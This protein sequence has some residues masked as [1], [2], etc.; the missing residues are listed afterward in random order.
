MPHGWS[1]ADF[2]AL[3]TGTPRYIA[4]MMRHATRRRGDWCN[5][6]SICREHYCWLE[7][8]QPCSELPVADLLEL[9]RAMDKLRGTADGPS[10]FAGDWVRAAFGLQLC[11]QAMSAH[12]KI[13]DRRFNGLI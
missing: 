3:S 6:V 12:A 7:P 4:G 5:T 10:L 8:D 2:F 11:A 9:H 1:F 13:R